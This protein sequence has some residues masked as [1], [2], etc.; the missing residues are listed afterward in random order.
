[1]SVSVASYQR[2][3]LINGV[4]KKEEASLVWSPSE[5]A[6]KCF[7]LG[8]RPEWREDK[9]NLGATSLGRFSLFNAVAVAV[10]PGGTIEISVAK[11]LQFG[12]GGPSA[13]AHER[14]YAGPPT[15]RRP[16]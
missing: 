2:G 3:A 10:C 14:R 13:L 7:G 8:T 9:E 15:G 12:K 1:L 16:V 11:T 4:F 6:I 5:I